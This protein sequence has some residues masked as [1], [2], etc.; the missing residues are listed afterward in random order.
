M[1]ININAKKRH[2]FIKEFL[3]YLTVQKN[4]APRTIKAYEHDL[5]KFFDFFT[6]YLEQELTLKDIDERTVMEFIAHLKLERNYSARSLNRKISSLKT[7]FKY[8][9]KEGY[10]PFTPLGKVDS[11]KLPKRL[12]KAF[13]M[14]ELDVLLNTIAK[15]PEKSQN[16]IFR[17]KKRSGNY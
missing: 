12:P 16:A 2:Y 3:L 10:I 15:E 17:K 1:D 7:Y 13:E 6:P 4:L 14:N 5:E 8:L 11:V 9:E